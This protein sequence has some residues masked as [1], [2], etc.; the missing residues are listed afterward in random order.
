MYKR[1]TY[2]YEI[3]EVIPADRG[4]YVYD[5]SVYAATVTVVEENGALLA[6]V[7][8]KKDGAALADGAVPEFTNAKAAQQAVSYTHLDVYKRQVLMYIQVVKNK[9]TKAI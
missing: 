6:S 2:T 4:G 7:V 3:S 9:F 5:E 8:Y 1:Q